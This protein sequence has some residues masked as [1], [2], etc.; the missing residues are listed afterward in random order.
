M[1]E[2]AA[3][4]DATVAYGEWRP[5]EEVL[6]EMIDVKPALGMAALLDL[7]TRPEPGD[8]LPPMW[9]W[10]YFVTRPRQSDIGP[11]GHAKRG[12]FWPPVELQ[13]RMFAGARLAY[14]RPLQIGRPATRR[15]IITAV[16]EKSGSRG[17]MVFATVTY[18]YEQDDEACFEEVFDA[19]YIG[20]Q[21]PI[22]AP[23]V[24]DPRWAPPA[25]AWSRRIEPDPVMLF[26][27]SSLTFNG[28]RI[29]YD[30]SYAHDVE[31]YPGLVVH[32]PLTAT[33][34]AELVRAR[35]P[36]PLTG[37]AFRARAPL[38]DL[39]PFY[40]VGEPEGGGTVAL[41]ARR[42]DGTVAMTATAETA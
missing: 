6:E 19:V 10:L 18:R 2:A 8:D 26:R 37:F 14:H 40:V 36:A 28:H 5:S 39:A 24:P 34:L 31:G 33:L 11:D 16:A 42:L 17:P 13:R 21:A 23:E 30:R 3:T 15:G 9:H 1:S 22:A 4:D 29:H 20:P 25:N 7:P 12:S 38:F 32:G 41:E 27:Y 35:E